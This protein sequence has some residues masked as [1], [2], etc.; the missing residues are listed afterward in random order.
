MRRAVERLGFS[1]YLSPVI[2]SANTKW[3]KPNPYIF[4]LVAREWQLDPAGRQDGT[5]STNVVPE[6]IVHSLSELPLAIADIQA[7]IESD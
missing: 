2:T 6:T 5:A 3:R 1:S 4:H 7:R